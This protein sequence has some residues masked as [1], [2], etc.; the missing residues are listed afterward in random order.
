MYKFKFLVFSLIYVMMWLTLPTNYATTLPGD[1]QS[2][3]SIFTIDGF[4]TFNMRTIYVINY[5][6]LTPFQ[7]QLLSWVDP[8]NVRLQTDYDEAYSLLELY[9]IGQIQKQSAYSLAVYYGYH[10]A[11]FSPVI[12]DIKYLV[13]SVPS[14]TI[15]LSI[16]DQITHINGTELQLLTD[17]NPFNIK[18][19]LTL[20]VIKEQ[21][22]KSI[23]WSR[24]ESDL[25]LLFYPVLE[26]SHLPYDI[27]LDGLDSMIGG[28]SG[29]MM[30][31]LSIVATLKGWS[32]D[33]MI[34]GTGTITR[35]GT[36]G[37]I[38]ALPQKYET[39]KHEMDYMLIPYTMIDELNDHDDPRIIGLQTIE[40]AIAFLES[41][42]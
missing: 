9:E 13:T 16:G 12:E 8:T 5:K 35:F 22:P 27:H 30:L 3:E 21:G 1:T 36:I 24:Q 6:P 19:T 26:F 14:S 7:Y 40:E 34:V 10:Y 17:F 41:L 2:T 11:G 29:G 20:T 15:D 23:T 33:E 18:D 38:G 32:I 42:Q 25:P 4:T 37:E 39:V 31:T 28:P